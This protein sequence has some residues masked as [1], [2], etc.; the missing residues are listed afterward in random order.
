MS[1]AIMSRLESL[2]NALTAMDPHTFDEG[3][4]D[5]WLEYFNGQAF[6]CKIGI[7]DNMTPDD[8][9][10]IRIVPNT[11]RADETIGL[12]RIECTVYFGQPVHAFAE[13]PDSAGRVRL[14]RLYAS[15]LTLEMAIRTTIEINGGIPGETVFDDD[16]LD[17]YKLMAVRCVLVG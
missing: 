7:E 6:T 11:A 8:Y 14:E 15:L 12:S 1:T 4:V 2:R 16:R 13:A 10:M 17:T 3:L 5:D 9:P